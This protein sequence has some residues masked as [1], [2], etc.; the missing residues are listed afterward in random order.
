MDWKNITFKLEELDYPHA[1]TKS[2][3]KSVVVRGNQFCGLIVILN[4]IGVNRAVGVGKS[5]E[6]DLDTSGRLKVYRGDASKLLSHSGGISY[7]KISELSADGRV[8]RLWRSKV[9]EQLVISSSGRNLLLI[10]RDGL[11]LFSH[12]PPDFG[13]PVDTSGRLRVL[14]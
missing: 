1:I 3:T 11:H 8:F 14:R 9:A 5:Y 4:E 10:D 13:L 7:D 2:K 6:F 12:V